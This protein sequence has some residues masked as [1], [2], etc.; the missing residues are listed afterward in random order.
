M[1][2]DPKKLTE[3]QRLKAELEDSNAR[4]D[5]ALEK[6]KKKHAEQSARAKPKLALVAKAK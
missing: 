4:A 2:P 5:V 1:K 3:A 6:L